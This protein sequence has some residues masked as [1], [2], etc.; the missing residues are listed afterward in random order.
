[1]ALLL[2][3][4]GLFSNWCWLSTRV[5]WCNIFPMYLF[6]HHYYSQKGSISHPS[7]NNYKKAIWYDSH[8]VVTRLTALVYSRFWDPFTIISTCFNIITR[9]ILCM[10]LSILTYSDILKHLSCHFR[11]LN[12]ARS[13]HKGLKCKWT[14]K[15]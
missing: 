9:N 15:L 13:E 12:Q 1:M 11:V 2:S 7:K 5:M 3:I 6:F 4:N 14:E 8:Q 10:L